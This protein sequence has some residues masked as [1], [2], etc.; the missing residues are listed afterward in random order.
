MILNNS[1]NVEIMEL[2]ISN[3]AEVNSMEGPATPLQMVVSE[4]NKEA[5]EVLLRHN[6]DV[7]S[8]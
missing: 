7:S 8:Q 4:G 6:A 1:G 5:V 3:G 2:L